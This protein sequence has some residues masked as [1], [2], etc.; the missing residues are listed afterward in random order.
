MLENLIREIGTRFGVGGDQARSIAQ[1]LLAYVT[2]P[3]T[4]GITGLL[5]R[6][7]SDGLDGMVQS[8]LGNTSNPEVPSNSQVESIFGSGTG[9]GMLSA[10][11]S[12]LDLSREKV[13]SVVG[14]LLP[15]LIG[16]LTPGGTVPAV[17]PAEIATLAEGGRGLLG[18]ALLG[19][20]A[21]STVP[22]VATTAPVAAASSSGGLAKWL[23]WIIGALIILFGINYCAKKKT[24]APAPAEVPAASAP[25]PA[26]AAPASEPA[27]MPAPV[28]SEAAV[29]APSSATDTA[30][31]GAAVLDSMAQ[32][33]PLL[34]VFFDTGKTE[35]ASEFGAKSK[36]F[37]D[38]LKA[39]ADVKAVISGF[40]D[41]TGDPAKNAELSKQR[42]EAVQSALVAAGVPADRT[43]L[44]KPAE[45]TD[46]GATNAASRRVDVMIRK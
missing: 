9:G 39:N 27:P 21:A 41:P 11:V 43:V 31:A 37:V 40:N 29:P 33:M 13:V 17:L 22:P 28:A 32:D 24:D 34:R 10:I 25:A 12:R 23:P 42:A 14:A 3:A 1:M 30:P 8:W 2:N 6:L 35:V 19:T 45:T 15:R 16:Y 20:A 36:A 18:P 4:G 46:T 44:E 5:Q 38:Y 7:R 26:P